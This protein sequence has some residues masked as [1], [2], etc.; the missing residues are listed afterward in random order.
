[1]KTRTILFA[2]EG[3]VLTD[4]ESYGTTVVL[5]EGRTSEEFHEI[6]EAEY[7]EIKAKE[8]VESAAEIDGLTAV[9]ETEGMHKEE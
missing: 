2:D 5:A 7:E 1:M 9:A 3:M 6:T 4:G 8:N